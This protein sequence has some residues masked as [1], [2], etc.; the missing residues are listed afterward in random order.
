M[1]AFEIEDIDD[2]APPSVEKKRAA[3][4][5][6]PPSMTRKRP[7]GPYFKMLALNATARPSGDGRWQCDQCEAAYDTRTGLFGHVRFCEGRNAWRCEWCACT[8]MQ[9]NHKANGPNG[10]KTLCSA[11]GA[12]FRG[13]AN[14]MP[15]QNDRGE[16][17]CGTC[18]RTFTDIR[19]LGSHRRFCDG[20]VWRCRWCMCKAEECSGKG[21]GPDGAS[22]LCAPCSGR[23]RSGHT[24]PPPTNADGKYVCELCD[25]TFDNITGLGSHRG[26]CDGGMW[27][28]GWCNC[29][30]EETSG[31]VRPRAAPA[32]PSAP[33]PPPVP[34]ARH[35]RATTQGPGPDGNK[36]L[37]STCSARFRSGHTKPPQTNDDGKYVCEACARTFDT[38]TALGGHKRFCDGGVWRC[39]WC[40]VSAEQTSGKGPGPDG[41]STLCAPCAGRFRSGHTTAVLPNADGKY[42]CEL[43]DRTFETIA[44]LGVHRRF[45][46]GGAWRCAWCSGGAEEVQGKGP[47]PDGAGTLCSACSSRYRGGATGPPTKDVDG[48]Y[49]CDICERTF[50]DIR[51]LGSHRRFCDGGAWRCAWCM[52]SA[53][54]TS[55]KGPGPDGASTLCANCAGR[56]RSGHTTAVLPN[57]DGKYECELCDRIF[58]TIAA[59]GVHRRSCDGGAWRCAWCEVSADQAQGKSPGPDGAGTLCS[60][61]GARFRGGHLGPPPRNAFGQIECECGRAFDKLNAL[62]THKRSCR[63]AQMMP[64]E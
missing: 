20:G 23:F 30:Y 62:A 43:C 42:D 26:R 21:P 51:G 40:S 15:Q 28:C 29:K 48:N 56:F 14:A 41:P 1:S 60:T 57:A 53:E 39:G 5:A 47:G 17:L 2:E 35:P 32:P 22:T 33:T 10:E 55:G 8:E 11:C 13:G 31:K 34:S 27:R 18:D 64:E 19:G 52:C 38:M 24:G 25:R 49:L 12:R 3:E 54:Q 16:F 45:C 4:G 50:T 36:T 58:E 9:T 61:C 7:K 59:L 46:D 37:C 63:V 44:A 6:L